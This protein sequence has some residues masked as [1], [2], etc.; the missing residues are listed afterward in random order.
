M[1]CAQGAEPPVIP[2]AYSIEGLR[3][4]D[5][6]PRDPP[7]PTACM[8][9]LR[10]PFNFWVIHQCCAVDGACVSRRNHVSELFFDGA[11]YWVAHFDV[12]DWVLENVSFHENVKMNIRGHHC[13]H[14]E[15]EHQCRRFISIVV[16]EVSCALDN[17]IHVMRFKSK[18]CHVLRRD[19]ARCAVDEAIHL[20]N[21]L[22]TLNIYRGIY[23]NI[24]V[25][26]YCR[27]SVSWTSE[28]LCGLAHIAPAFN[29]RKE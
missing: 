24:G 9:Y 11:K 6:V 7:W 19:D 12:K 22:H 13:R 5:S 28:T 10:T 29:C 4:G 18:H 15:T 16:G 25:A 1:V 27:A 8:F 21:Q 14:Q 3:T 23:G 17:G 26:P 2:P 20:L